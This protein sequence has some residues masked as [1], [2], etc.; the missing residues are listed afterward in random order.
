MAEDRSYH[1]LLRDCAGLM[2]R[3]RE[4]RSHRQTEKKVPSKNK[5]CSIL[6]GPFILFESSRGAE[7]RS[8]LGETDS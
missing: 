3:E 4:S 8:S 6:S 5:K 2:A 7:S 1:N